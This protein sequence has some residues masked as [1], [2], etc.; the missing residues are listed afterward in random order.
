MAV[1]NIQ[2]FDDIASRVF[3]EL[4]EN[5][6]L[7]TELATEDYLDPAT[8]WN[9]TFQQ[10]VIIDDG[11]FFLATVQWL[12]KAGYVSADGYHHSRV[13]DVVLTAKGLEVLRAI[14]GSLKGDPSI[15]EQL[16]SAAKT[17]GKE[18]MRGLFSQA[19]GV[20]VRLI[21]PYVGLPN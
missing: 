9:E 7:P 18:A 12:E 6:P 3:A 10:D 8:E 17:G 19:L 5:F 21:S 11:E 20:G 16:A 14:P 15:G 4:Y 2:R 13:S 1:S